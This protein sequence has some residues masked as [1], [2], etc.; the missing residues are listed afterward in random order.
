MAKFKELDACPPQRLLYNV[1]IGAGARNSGEEMIS[2]K[3]QRQRATLTV[4]EEKNHLQ[5]GLTNLA[6]FF[7]YTISGGVSYLG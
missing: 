5:L 4:T 1:T 2:R 3:R 7:F 6:G